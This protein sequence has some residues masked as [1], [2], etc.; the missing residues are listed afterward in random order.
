MVRISHHPAHL[1][2][3]TALHKNF[4]PKTTNPFDQ[5]SNSSSIKY[6]ELYEASYIYLYTYDL[7]H[8]PVE[9]RWP[10]LREPIIHDF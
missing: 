7:Y 2:F 6:F 1:T 8:I 10:Q 4:H 9:F 3:D 5:R